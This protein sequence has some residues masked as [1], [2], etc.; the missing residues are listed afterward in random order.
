MNIFIKF[1]LLAKLKSE[2]QNFGIHHQVKSRGKVSY[3]ENKN[4]DEYE[5]EDEN[6]PSLP[7]RK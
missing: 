7:N 1:Q 2:G 3:L 6:H 5:F 4:I